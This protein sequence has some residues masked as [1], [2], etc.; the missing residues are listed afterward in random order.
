[1]VTSLFAAELKKRR[2]PRVTVVVTVFVFLFFSPF[3]DCA[4]FGCCLGDTQ[5]STYR[6]GNNAS[7]LNN[8][9]HKKNKRWKGLLGIHGG[10]VKRMLQAYMCAY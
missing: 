3:F 9:R 2:E 6:G 8:T 10:V 1:M 7:R 5:Q 4:F